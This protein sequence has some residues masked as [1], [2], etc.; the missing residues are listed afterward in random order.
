MRGGAGPRPGMS[1][2]PPGVARRLHQT[3]LR[4]PARAAKPPGAFRPTCGIGQGQV[5][6]CRAGAYASGGLGR[7]LLPQPLRARTRGLLTCASGRPARPQTAFTPSGPARRGP[8]RPRPR[9]PRVG[10]EERRLRNRQPPPVPPPRPPAFPSS[11]GPRAAA[12]AVP[13]RSAAR[14]TTRSP[15]ETGSATS[16]SQ[17]VCRR[18]AGARWDG[19]GGRGGTGAGWRRA[20]W[21]PP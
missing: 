5:S 16:Q 10:E 15:P 18:E 12:A 21:F 7:G 2:A 14:R 9:S 19:R 11:L 13:N 1:S 3:P 6:S 17:A 8:T 4:A 20:P